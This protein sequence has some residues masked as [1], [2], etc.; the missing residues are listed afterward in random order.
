MPIG[1]RCR[2]HTTVGPYPRLDPTTV[3][4][5]ASQPWPAGSRRWRP[6]SANP[7][8]ATPPPCGGDDG[9][10]R[11]AAVLAVSEAA[12]TVSPGRSA[13]CPYSE[14][15]R[16]A[17]IRLSTQQQN[18]TLSAIAGQP[19]LSAV[20]EDLARKADPVLEV[21]DRIHFRNLTEAVVEPAAPSSQFAA[22]M[23]CLYRSMSGYAWSTIN[24]VME[25]VDRGRSSTLA[26]LIEPRRQV[27]ATARRP[28]PGGM[29]TAGRST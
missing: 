1:H 13:I 16:H 2:R 27:H 25:A 19:I 21:P 14:G 5:S 22:L 18:A 10:R 24:A 12:V 28:W 7:A 29:S 11:A 9:R 8:A 23:G 20:A 15:M 26:P 3:E 6:R 4:A 17:C